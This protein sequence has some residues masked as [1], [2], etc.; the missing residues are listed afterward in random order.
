MN[1]EQLE[2]LQK[3][4]DEIMLC[5]AE[6][7]T[8]EYSQK[9]QAYRA[10]GGTGSMLDEG[11]DHEAWKSRTKNI[12]PSN[13]DHGEMEEHPTERQSPETRWCGTWYD[14]REPQCMASVLIKSEA[15]KAQLEEQ[16]QQTAAEFHKLKGKRQKERFLKHRPPAIVHRLLQEVN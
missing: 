10:A 8:E 2:Q 11:L 14:C 3:A 15:L 9:W 16:Y 4:Y 1:K 13:S 7:G 6:P 12:C 5:E